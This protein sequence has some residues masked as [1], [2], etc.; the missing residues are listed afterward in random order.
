MIKIARERSVRVADVMTDALVVLDM[1]MT[2]ETAARILA[3]RRISGAP[4]VAATGRPIGVV[5][6]I[7]LLD[8]RHQG[9]DAT[10]ENAMTKVLYAVRPGDPAMAAV[11]LM[12]AENIHRVVVVD[13]EHG[14]LVGIITSM[15]VMRA[16]AQGEPDDGVALEYVRVG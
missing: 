1:R 12:V 15:D 4:V 8:P 7:D 2:V 6:T 16:L 13:E 10:V 11:R 9:P 3:E 14:K 5:T